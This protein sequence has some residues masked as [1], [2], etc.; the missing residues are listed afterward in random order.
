MRNQT[1]NKVIYNNQNFVFRGEYEIAGDPKT[2]F[3]EEGPAKDRLARDFANGVI[4]TIL[5][6][7]WAEVTKGGGF[8]TPPH[9]KDTMR[10]LPAGY[11]NPATASLR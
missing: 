6:V 1:T 10:R 5:D 8:A 2:Y 3:N 9:R 11:L 4:S 7:F